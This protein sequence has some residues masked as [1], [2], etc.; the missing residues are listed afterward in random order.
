MEENLEVVS[1]QTCVLIV[2]CIVSYYCS[3]ILESGVT[4]LIHQRSYKIIYLLHWTVVRPC[5]LI[6]SIGNQPVLIS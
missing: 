4:F 3:L 5:W 2:D 1:C 6:S